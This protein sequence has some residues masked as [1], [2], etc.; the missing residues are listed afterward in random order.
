MENII[1]TKIFN[2]RLKIVNLRRVV[3]ILGELSIALLK[4]K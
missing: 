4:L 3:Q 1:L 2:F